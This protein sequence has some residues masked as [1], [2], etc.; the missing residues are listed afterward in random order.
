[1]AKQSCDEER[2]FFVTNFQSSPNGTD[3]IAPGSSALFATW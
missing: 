1:M 2:A 3:G